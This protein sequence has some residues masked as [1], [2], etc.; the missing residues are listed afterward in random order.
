MVWGWHMCTQGEL[1][2][3]KIVSYH[4]MIMTSG[5]KVCYIVV[6]STNLPE[7]WSKSTGEDNITRIHG[8]APTFLDL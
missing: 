3:C 1:V 6:F 4:P 8:G 2:C 7:F 5:D